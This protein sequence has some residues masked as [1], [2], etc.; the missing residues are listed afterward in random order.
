MAQNYPYRAEKEISL[1]KV[2]KKRPPNWR[3]FLHEKNN[4]LP[5]GAE[6]SSKN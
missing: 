6:S 3:P 5:D 1:K 4:Y 2:Y